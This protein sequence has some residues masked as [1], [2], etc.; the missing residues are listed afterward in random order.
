L[1][2]EDFRRFSQSYSEI[3]IKRLPTARRVFFIPVV[4]QIIDYFPDQ[5]LLAELIALFRAV[6]SGEKA[7]AIHME[8]LMLPFMVRDGGRI[9]AIVDGAD[10][11]FLKK[12]SDD[13]LS[14]TRAEVEREFLLLKEARVDVQTGLL[15][16][17][18]LYSLLDTYS[19]TTGLRL[20]LV[21]L[22]PPRASFRYV[23]RYSQKCSTLILNFVQG[24]SVL[25]YLGQCTFALV[26]QNSSATDKTEVESALVAYLKREGCH[27]VHIG[28]S[29]SRDF[30]SAGDA[31]TPG[32]YLLDEAWTALRH[33]AKR[34]PFNFCDYGLLAHPERHPLALP[35]GNLV[36]RLSRQWLRSESFSLVH[37]RSL[38]E[39]HTAKEVVLPGIDQGV[40]ITTDSDVLV[41]LDGV[42]AHAALAWARQLILRIAEATLDSRVSAGVSGYPC[43]D[44]K[45]S[46]MVFNCRKALL[47]AAFFGDSSAVVFDSVSLNISGDIYFGDGDLAKA[48]HEYKRGLKYD[49][50]N[51]NLHNSLGVALAMMDKLGPAMQSFDN[52][53]ALDSQNFMALYN[54][55]LAELARGKKE[56]A[57]GYF[58]KA[59]CH[60]NDEDAG[61][62]LIDDL[63]LQLGILAGDLGKHQTALGYLQA[64]YAKNEKTQR[65]GKAHYHIGKAHHGNGDNRSAMVELQRALQFNEF[66]DRAMNLLGSVYYKERQGDEIALALCRKSVELE[67]A[68]ILY[69]CNLAEVQVQCKMMR[70]A[71]ENLHRCLKSNKCRVKAQVLLGR[72]YV[73]DGMNKRA[74]SWFAKALRE[75][76]CP[77]E[78]HD[79]AKRGLRDISGQ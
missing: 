31:P 5:P 73:R 63:Q 23:L 59:L 11:V 77:P 27:K 79:E 46:E 38:G 34:G 70:E 41:F 32:R 28:S 42:D 65:A 61:I 24:N 13:W 1:V 78:L 43:S 72:S 3:L 2:A 64:W 7:F 57:Y 40:P 69:R 9:V 10:P 35:E 62:G 37:F 16:L 48:V 26:V 52:A 45:K 58:T 30:V 50:Q 15:N 29:F 55:G 44:F 12:V 49:A 67:P 76:N 21:E 39:G 4:A 6:K 47:H 68:N 53:L 74:A 8:F 56:E 54:L 14:Q 18:N 66:D 75:E 51:V 33:A 36:R 22:P 71:R 20:I 25:H 17:S 60:Y 19:Q